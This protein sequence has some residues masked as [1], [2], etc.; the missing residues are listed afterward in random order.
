MRPSSFRML[1]VRF[2]ER[3]EISGRLWR[4][5]KFRASSISIDELFV[6]EKTLSKMMDQGRAAA[7]VDFGCLESEGW[8]QIG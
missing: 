7:R 2:G 4:L 6:F 5:V 3:W 1:V 8:V